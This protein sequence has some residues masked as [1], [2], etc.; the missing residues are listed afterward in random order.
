MT[1]IRDGM[2][3]PKRMIVR[4]LFLI[5]ALA[6]ICTLGVGQASAAAIT[7]KT[8]VSTNIDLFVFVPCA[9]NGAGELVILS[10]PLHMLFVTTVD[11]QGG[12]HTLDHFQPQGITGTG[13]TSGDKYQAVGETL[14]TFNGKVGFVDTYVNNFKIIGVGPNNNFMIHETFHITVNANGVVTANVDHFS[15][16]CQ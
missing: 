16:V 11:N 6:L 8:N 5:P 9:D 7:T 1:K 14:E 2:S 13:Q 10:G 12:Y 15:A 3:F 4:F